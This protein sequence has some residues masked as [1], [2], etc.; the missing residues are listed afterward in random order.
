MTYQST[1]N[2]V[3]ALTMFMLVPILLHAAGPQESA[4]HAFSEHGSVNTF[5]V[6]NNPSAA[7]KGPDSILTF[8]SRGNSKVFFGAENNIVGL[9]DI[10]CDPKKPQHIFV[11]HSVFS[12]KISGFL[13]FN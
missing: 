4:V 1:R 6:I 12:S 9:T 10:A 2:P 8:D 13:I 5:F 7:S 3:F 11:G